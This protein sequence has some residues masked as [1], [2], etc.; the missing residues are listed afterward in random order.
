[1]KLRTL[2]LTIPIAFILAGCSRD[3]KP[4]S[5]ASPAAESMEHAAIDSVQVPE[6][7]I[8]DFMNSTRYSGASFSPD[9]SKLLMSNN[10]T[11]IFNVYAIAIDGRDTEQLTFS[12][13]DALLAISYFPED[14]RFLYTAD[15]AGNELNHLY[16]R[17]M[18]GS[19][20][21][22]TPGE[23]LKASFSGWSENYDSFF[24]QT[25][26]RDP[27]FFDVYEY[28]LAEGYPREMIFLNEEGFF[29]FQV[30]PDGQFLALAEL[31]TADNNNL[32]VQNLISGE[33]TLVTPHDGNVSSVPSD[34]SP[35]SASLYYTTDEGSEFQQLVRYDIVSGDKELVLALDWDIY[36]GVFSREGKY[37]V[38]AANVDARTELIMF[39]ATTMEQIEAPSINGANVTNVQFSHGDELI[40]MYGSGSRFPSDLFVASAQREEPPSRL[41]SSLNASINAN[42][43]VDAKVV[44]FTS[45][46][47]V[48][49][50]GILWVPHEASKDN[51]APALVWV[52]GGPGGQTR[53]T[54][55]G[56]IQYLVNHGYVVYGINN[57]GSS[58]YGKTFYAMD[59]KRHGE[60]DLGDVVASKQMLIDTGVVD[61]DKVG[62][63][64]GSYGG[65]MV[66]AALAFEPN[67][68]NVGVD[69]FG[70]TNWLRTLESIPPWWA[71]QKDALYD[72]MGDPA[73]DRERLER[74]SPLFHAENIEKPMIV[75][76]G[77]N[78]PRVLQIESDE[79]VAAVRRN[80][81]H[82]DY[83]VFPDEGH[84]FRNRE[85]EI[86]GYRSI[87][88]FLDQYL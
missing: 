31:I 27:R 58:G 15:Q 45:Y 18:D 42:H 32:H 59:N 41:T 26:E 56:L 40:A 5:P 77:A 79:M 36:Y 54:Y 14:E 2:S 47:G 6:Y 55:S 10:S 62:I 38:V 7:S 50:P 67:V 4:Q 66:V 46:D 17:E 73:I 78:D 16:V 24:V 1:M 69:I 9:N 44:R 13:S 70:V 85:N 64:G 39:D 65:Y 63:I 57:R 48:E 29:P 88:E 60:A 23:D 83:I 28:E 81:V 72:E 53:A 68:F 33:R 35:D 22:L 3:S 87:R 61:P 11:G 84:G 80:D 49:V 74:I 75:L 8:E 30:S 34:F 86:N 25:N 52:H 37:F 19:E 82:V 76:Q 71:A 51:L 21:D 12:E 20:I 43:L